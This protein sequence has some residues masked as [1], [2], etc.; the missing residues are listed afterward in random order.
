MFDAGIRNLDIVPDKF[1]TS[2]PYQFVRHP[3]YLGM[4][5]A[6]V[7]WWWVFSAIYSFYFGM[8]ILALIWIEAYLEEKYSLVKIFGEKYI[9]YRRHTG[10]F[11][12]K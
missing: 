5:F 9:E 11:W 4:I 7:G 12:I 3:L 2:G 10:M 1:I 6:C 8:I